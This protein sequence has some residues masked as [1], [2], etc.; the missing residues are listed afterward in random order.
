M[1]FKYGEEEIK[2]AIWD[3]GS[4]KSLGP[5]RYNFKL[6]KEFWRVMKRD[7]INFLNDF[8]EFGNF[9]KGANASFITLILKIL[10]HKG[11]MIINQFHWW[12]VCIRW[13]LRSWQRDYKK[14][15][16]GGV[17]YKVSC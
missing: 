7:V 5:N 13:W 1:L 8:H 11:G 4:S 2:K 17:S 3:C 12:G 10:S 9:P 15:F 14:C 16:M 6:I